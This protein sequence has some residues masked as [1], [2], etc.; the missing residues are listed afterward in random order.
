MN[1]PTEKELAFLQWLRNNGAEIDK[2][3]W[4]AV[5]PATGSRGAMAL[6]NIE[7]KLL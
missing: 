2:L 7:V 6:E 1:A 3:A 5:D 4:P